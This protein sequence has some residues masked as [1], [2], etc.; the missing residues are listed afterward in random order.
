MSRPFP[1]KCATCRE[2]AVQPVRLDS[3]AT[4]IEHEGR[5]YELTLAD[6]PGTRCDVCQTLILDESVSDRIDDQLRNSVG[7]LHPGEI[8]TRREALRLTQGAVANA[9]SVGEA[10]FARW[11][12][13]AQ[14]QPRGMD[15]FLR[16]FLDLPDLRT[17]LAGHPLPVG[18]SAVNELAH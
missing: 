16:A 9:L 8:K 17:Y 7:L 14:I 10:T 12:S 3:Y 13:G 1:R 18:I 5:S 6:V 15:R 2:R 4:T 11:E